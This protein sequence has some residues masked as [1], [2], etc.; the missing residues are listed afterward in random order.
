VKV[1]LENFAFMYVLH[2]DLISQTIAGEEKTECMVMKRHMSQN[3]KFW[4][5][6]ENYS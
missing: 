6:G 5:N 3:P 1:F 2:F 4:Q